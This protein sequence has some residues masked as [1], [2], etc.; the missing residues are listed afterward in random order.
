MSNAQRLVRAR[1]PADAFGN[2]RSLRSL[3]C[4]S[5]IRIAT[6]IDTFGKNEYVKKVF[7]TLL[8]AMVRLVLARVVDTVT[9]QQVVGIISGMGGEQD[10]PTF[11]LHQTDVEFIDLIPEEKYAQ[12]RLLFPSR[13]ICQ[14]RNTP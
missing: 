12:I 1:P 4:L 6:M 8:V 13:Y 3:G 2:R 11:T 5:D 9:A 10:P 14:Y 7:W